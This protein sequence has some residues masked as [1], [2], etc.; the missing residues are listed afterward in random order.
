MTFKQKVWE[1]PHL[2]I[3]ITNRAAGFHMFYEFFDLR[4]MTP[5]GS[6]MYSAPN[7]MEKKIILKREHIWWKPRLR[8]KPVQITAKKIV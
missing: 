7:K 4:T 5:F 2:P 3:S 1:S 8:E 6:S